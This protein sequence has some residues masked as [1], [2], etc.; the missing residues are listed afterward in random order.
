MDGFIHIRNLLIRKAPWTRIR[1]Y[2]RK[3][4]RCWQIE[5]VI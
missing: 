3:L 4:Y 2:F 5:K 1:Y